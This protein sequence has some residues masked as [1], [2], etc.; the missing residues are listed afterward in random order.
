M[1]TLVHVLLP[2]L[3]IGLCSLRL[4]AQNA[5]TSLKPYRDAVGTANATGYATGRTWIIVQFKGDALY[6]YTNAS[7][8]VEHIR[9]L[10]RLAKLGEGLDA[11]ISK[12]VWKSYA[13]KLR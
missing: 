10:K 7:C 4:R 13:K 2:F 3:L 9:E 6:L 8:G 12:H 1:K 5:E 11:Y